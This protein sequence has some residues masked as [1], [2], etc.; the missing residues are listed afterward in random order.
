MGHADTKDG[1][2]VFYSLAKLKPGATVEVTRR[3]RSIA[4]FEVN[5][6]ERFGKSKLP[7]DRVYGDYTRPGLRLVT[8]GG[9]WVGGASDI[10]TTSSRS[11]RSWRRRTR[12]TLTVIAVL[13]AEGTGSAA[14]RSPCAPESSS[15]LPPSWR[16]PAVPALPSRPTP[17]P[18]AR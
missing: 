11:R 9:Q 8:C 14:R 4:I 18:T 3:D 5:S 16:P 1:P 17:P 13:T 10:R 2:S 15:P 12:D 6:V 7:A